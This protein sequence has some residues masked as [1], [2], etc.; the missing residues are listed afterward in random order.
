MKQSTTAATLHRLILPIQALEGAAWLVRMCGS[1]LVILGLAAWLARLGWFDPPYWVL[2]GWAVAVVAVLG[3]VV[4]GWRH[5]GRLALDAIAR[6]LEEDGVSRR[7]ALTGLLVPPVDGTSGDLYRLADRSRASELA[8]SGR[9]EVAPMAQA[10]RGRAAAAAS[11]FLFGVLL[12]AS[13]GPVRGAAAQLWR[14]KAAWDRTTAPV[15]LQA[16]DTIVDRGHS[17]DLELAAVGRRSAALWTRSPGEAWRSESVALDEAGRATRT[18]EPLASDLHARLV[19]GTR[20]SET[21]TVRVRL[22]AFLGALAVVARYPP[23]LG[24]ADEPLPT[25][26]DTLLLPAG[27]VLATSGE[28]TTML[29]EA[30]WLVATTSHPLTVTGSTFQGQ[31]VPRN[32]GVYRLAI[33]TADGGS[34][35][36]DIPRLPIR[37]VSDS[38][39]SVEV[40]VPGRDTLLPSTLRIPIVVDA[41][42]DHGLREIRLTSRRISRLG[43]VNEP[44]LER[45]PLPEGQ[46]D[47][48]IVSYDFNLSARSL[49]P[50]DSVRYLVEV[51]DN[52]PRPNIG[53][54]REYRLRLPTLREIRART[55][56]ATAE[57]E[58][59]LDSLAKASRRIE[60][61]TEDLSRERTRGEQGRTAGQEESLAFED[62]KRAEAAAQDHETLVRQ[63]EAMRDALDALRETA[64]AAGLDDPDWQARLEEIRQQLDRALSPEIREK[65]AELQQALLELN[66]QRTRDALERLAEAQ[67]E[68]REVLERSRDLFR[69]AA[70]EG[71]LA[72]LEQDARELAARQ[73]QWNSEVGSADSMQAAA[74]ERDLAAETDSLAKVLEQLAEALEREGV[75]D[76]NDL[77][78]QAMEAAQ[79]MLDA[80]EQ[81]QSGDRSAAEQSG[82]QALQ[83]LQPLGNQIGAERSGL[84]QRWREEIAAALDRG[85]TEVSRLTER[86]LELERAIRSDAPPGRVLADQGAIEEGVENLIQQM[87]RASGKNA[88]VSP[89]IAGALA[90][91]QLQM[92]RAREGLASAMPNVRDAAEQAGQAVDALNAAAYQMVRS[93]G[94]VTGAGTGSGL[95]EALERLSE[96]AKQQGQ[97]GERAGGLI[98]LAGGGMLREQLR[99]LAQEQRQLAEELERIR[100]SGQLPNSG[101]LAEE[102]RDLARRLEAGRLDQQTVERQQRLF[103]RML[104]AG[105]TLQGREEDERKERQSQ[106]ATGDNIR[107]PPALGALVNRGASGPQIPSWEEL[108]RFSPEE[109]RL[110][111]EYFRR[112]AEPAGRP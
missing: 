45:I 106:T 1:M 6:V 88:L 89:G 93:R 33:R 12:I 76:A 73:E 18:T 36:G 51:V 86:Q 75:T 101:A 59:R 108:Q 94:D 110:V 10:A 28:A 35:G 29:A 95:A 64:E 32:S 78:R 9:R 82:R 26:G 60:R 30:N 20:S 23:Y 102:A 77:V 7:G 22:P 5:R 41:R 17:V 3:A 21:I 98:P 92:R 65:L 46:P 37:V 99:R 111:V 43:V 105:R 15:T 80:A 19:S 52:A 38:A 55:R 16:S 53:R 97:L 90:Q 47:R 57:L 4:R 71:D 11:L 85:L 48:A 91:A 72:N 67:R 44:R 54:S 70:L 81:A 112:L 96:L 62:A 83:Q 8:E 63:A 79:Q 56:E 27:T 100:A 50:G 24:L 61:R 14:P 34:L 66:A 87:Q 69:R 109:R 74:E 40:P 25:G 49:L 39:P 58:Q 42:D 31:F 68:L 103:R 104:D 107:L 13:A 2:V 84:Q